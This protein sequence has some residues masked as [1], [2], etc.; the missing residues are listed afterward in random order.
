MS[1][2]EQQDDPA[3]VPGYSKQT[4]PR[5]S[6]RKKPKPGRRPLPSP[7]EEELNEMSAAEKTKVARRIRNRKGAQKRNLREQR[8]QQEDKTLENALAQIQQLK[9][10]LATQTAE[11]DKSK[12]ELEEYK[13]QQEQQQTISPFS[14]SSYYLSGSADFGLPPLHPDDPMNNNNIKSHITN[15]PTPTT[16]AA[17]AVQAGLDL[18]APPPPL[19]TATTAPN[20]LGFHQPDLDSVMQWKYPGYYDSSMQYHPY[21]SYNNHHGVEMEE[22]PLVFTPFAVASSPREEGLGLLDGVGHMRSTEFS[23]WRPRYNNDGATTLQNNNNIGTAGVSAHDLSAV[24][25]SSNV[26]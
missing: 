2:T 10:E 3:W 4:S 12:A 17:A 26:C 21:Y 22:P 19:Q 8:E 15:P 5:S 7:T 11:M 18:P 16:K 20:A 13:A 23:A 1:N 6:Q 9:D 14:S 24:V 25:G